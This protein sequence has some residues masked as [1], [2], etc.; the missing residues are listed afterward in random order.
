V[1]SI[2]LSVEIYPESRYHISPLYL[3]RKGLCGM[4]KKSDKTVMS[5]TIG[6][7][8]DRIDGPLKVTGRA[9]YTGDVPVAGVLHAV[10]VQATIASGR[11]SKIDT[12]TAGALPGVVAIFS[13]ANPAF[14]PAKSPK[15]NQ[16]KRLLWQDN[17]VYYHGQIIALVVANSLEQAQHAA[18]LVKV[19]YRSSPG[20]T[21]IATGA[22]ALVVPNGQ[23]DGGRGNVT[24]ALGK[25][26]V[27]IRATYKTP[28]ESHNPMEP[29]ATT[30]VWSG[31]SLTLY[32]STQAISGTQKT[33]AQIFGVE[34]DKVRVIS[35]YVGGGFGCKLSTWSHV[36]LTAMAAHK[37]NRPVKLVLARNQMFGPVGFRPQTVQTVTLGAKKDGTLTAIRHATISET[38]KFAEFVELSSAVSLNAYACKNVATSQRVSPLDIGKPTWMRAPGHTPG[39]FALESAM[40]ELA[41][42]LDMDP[43]ALRLLNFA[44]T[45][46]ESGLPWSSNALKEC[47]RQGA[48]RFGWGKRKPRPG[49]MRQDGLL[50]GM[51][52]ATAVHSCWRNPSHASVRLLPDGSAIAQAGTQEIGTGTYTIMTQIAAENLGLPTTQVKFELGDSDLPHAPLSGG[53]TTAGSVGPAVALAAQTALANLIAVALA[54]KESP[55]Y[56][57]EEEAIVAQGGRLKAVGSSPAREDSYAAIVGRTSQ[58]F[59]EARVENKLGDEEKRYSMSTF[60]AQFAEVTIDPDL[61]LLKVKRFV[62]AYS[63]GRI[64]NAKTARSQMTGGI[65]FGIGMALMEQTIMDHEANRYINNNFGEYYVPVNADIPEID[66]FFVEDE[67][68]HI[69]SLGAKGIGELGITGVAAAIANAVYHA[70][71]KRVRDLPITLDKLL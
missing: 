35:H 33:I 25:A 63:G 7:P 46:Q 45:D 22:K 41:C 31:Q 6:K 9:P 60:G 5:T 24:D 34:P 17:K 1:K 19:S 44:D 66:A 27:K 50:V 18:S 20:D 10:A 54:D 3:P 43:I 11:I 58:K 62:G 61:G 65:I 13:H 48:E 55:L 26:A 40:D 39:S 69:N 14:T 49:S 8:L 16:E 37:L 47:Y 21:T 71:G 29:F 56:G 52:M 15:N 64:L 30:A 4:T 42:Q 28:T 12:G 32:D 67:D 51:G 53:S 38:S 57:A 36:A 2:I 23:E 59:I 70:T 68:P